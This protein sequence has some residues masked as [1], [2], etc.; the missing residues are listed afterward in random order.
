MALLSSKWVRSDTSPRVVDFKAVRYIFESGIKLEAK[1]QVVAMAATLY[2]RFFEECNPEDYDHYLIAATCLYLAGKV[3]ENH[4][5]IRDI[6]NVFHKAVHPQLEPL[7]LADEYWLLRDSIVQCELL[8]LRVM[9][10]QVS[11]D[12]PHRYLLHYLKSVQDWIAPDILAKLP[13]FRTCWSLLCDFYHLPSCLRY[14]PQHVAVA[15]IYLALECYGVTVLY[16][17]DA[18]LRWHD[19]FCEDLGKDQLWKIMEDILSVYD[20]ELL[21]N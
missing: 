9:K 12:H 20:A 1:P 21:E 16:N 17:N 5:K 15:I 19:T 3:E 4:L 8:L 6:V 2:H 11:V 13:L 14:K 10:F 7:D 18:V